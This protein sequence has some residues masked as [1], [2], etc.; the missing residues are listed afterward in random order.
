MLA[1]PRDNP[2]A[3]NAMDREVKGG[4]CELDLT[5]SNTTKRLQPIAFISKRVTTHSKK[6]LHLFMGEAGT[7]VWAMDKFRLYLFGQEFT[8]IC[9]CSG[10]IIVFDTNELPTHQAQRWELFMLRF[11]FTM[12]HRPDWMM[13]DVD[14]LSRYNN[15]VKVMKD[16]DKQG[17]LA[18]PTRT[19]P[20]RAEGQRITS[21]MI[22]SAQAPRLVQYKSIQRVGPAGAPLSTLARATTT[23]RNIWTINLPRSTEE[24][25]ANTGI[26]NNAMSR[27]STQRKR[28]KGE[29]EPIQQA[30]NSRAVELHDENWIMAEF[31]VDKSKA[32]ANLP[33]YW[34][35]SQ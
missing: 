12:V 5:S 26:Q 21:L 24:S 15:W 7:G 25:I 17:A 30:E 34:N 4:K 20:E 31:P 33:P 22:Q 35:L 29:I 14:M 6:A 11:D 2:K 19:E 3:I 23:H 28:N 8:W 13:R 18:A 1:Q 9:D 16:R 32:K 27:M 10:L